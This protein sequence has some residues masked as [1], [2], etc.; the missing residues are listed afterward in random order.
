MPNS[1]GTTNEGENGAIS[2][3]QSPSGDAGRHGCSGEG[4]FSPASG[5]RRCISISTRTPAGRSGR[6]E[7]S[8]AP[9]DAGRSAGVRPRQSSAANSAKSAGT[10]CT[11]HVCRAAS[12]RIEHRR[13]IVE[14]ARGLKLDLAADQLAGGWIER[15][16]PA[17]KMRSPVT[18]ALAYGRSLGA[19]SVDTLRRSIRYLSFA[20]AAVTLARAISSSR[21]Q[22]SGD[23]AR[24]IVDHARDDRRSPRAAA[25]R[26]RWPGRAAPIADG[27][28]TAVFSSGSEPPPIVIAFR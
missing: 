2:A 27:P 22:R 3:I 23:R 9:A 25:P 7:R 14:D 5:G 21:T 4:L 1:S 13:E 19:F 8:N 11:S 6:A 26:C 15:D 20:S 28:R 12:G 18:I 10:R 17:Q 24:S 16:R